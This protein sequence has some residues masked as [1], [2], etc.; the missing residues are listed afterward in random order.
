MR[1]PSFAHYLPSR[2]TDR[3]SDGNPSP[4]ASVSHPL[5]DTLHPRSVL[6]TP[7]ILRT[8][9]SS[10][11]HPR[12]SHHPPLA[13]R[14]DMQPLRQIP[15]PHDSPL[16]LPTQ[17]ALSQ[18]PWALRGYDSRRQQNDP[19][20]H[21]NYLRTARD[22]DDYQRNPLPP[23]AFRQHQNGD[24]FVSIAGFKVIPRASSADIERDRQARACGQPPPLSTSY[25]LRLDYASQRNTLPLSHYHVPQNSRRPEGDQHD[26]KTSAE[27]VKL[28]TSRP[29]P[30]VL[31]SRLDQL[32]RRDQHRATDHIFLD[33]VIELYRQ[34]ITLQEKIRE[35]SRGKNEKRDTKFRTVFFLLSLRHVNVSQAFWERRCAMF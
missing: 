3:P 33:D 19:S 35:K 18:S 6:C 5:S 7:N 1:S 2:S 16:S 24:C 23:H 27:P 32:V 13:P 17:Y 34:E 28:R 22:L 29:K 20:N 4:R 11:Q 9:I 14:L 31:Y 21:T 15:N 8:H 10:Q 26:P 30:H 12:P 25:G